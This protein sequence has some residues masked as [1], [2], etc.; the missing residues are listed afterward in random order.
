MALQRVR[1]RKKASITSLIDVIFLLLLFFMLASTFSRFSEVELAAA[2]IGNP[3]SGPDR[4][5]YRL[6]IGQDFVSLDGERYLGDGWTERFSALGG[7]GDDLVLVMVTPKATTQRL[8]STL[9]T[10]TAVTDASV[11]VVAEP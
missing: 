8:V 1:K 4:S 11:R 7:A 10:L 2:E 9:T 5:I 6:T 3:T